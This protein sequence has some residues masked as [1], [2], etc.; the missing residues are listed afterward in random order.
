VMNF[1]MHRRKAFQR[2]DPYWDNVALYLPMTGANGSTV[3]TDVSKY[4]HTVTRNGGAIISTAQAP[5]LAGVGSSG[6]FDGSGDSL[7]V[8]YSSLLDLA[9]SDFTIEFW[10]RT[11]DISTGRF[12]LDMYR[13]SLISTGLVIV[14]PAA[15][16]SKVRIACGD[17]NTTQFEVDITSS[18]S[19]STSAWSYVA[20]IRSGSTFSL[21]VNGALEGSSTWA[22]TINISASNVTIGSATGGSLGF[23]GYLSHLRVTKGVARDVSVVPTA[24]FPIG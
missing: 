16:P 21:Y 19:I 7:S 22:G 8:T 15:A 13:S 5:A 2:K 23:L 3:F 12:I 9:T 17:S 4:G 11:S 6:Y 20:A 10:V 14:Q 18:S 24:P 1:Q